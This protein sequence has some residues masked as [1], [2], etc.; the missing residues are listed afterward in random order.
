MTLDELQDLVEDTVF[1]ALESGV[2]L[3][4]E[5]RLEVD[6]PHWN[7]QFVVGSHIVHVV[8]RTMVNFQEFVESQIYTH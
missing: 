1:Q 8:S 5:F 6:E 7:H 3:P 4:P 2:E